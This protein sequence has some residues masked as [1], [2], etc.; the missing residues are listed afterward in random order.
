MATSTLFTAG[1]I[2]YIRATQKRSFLSWTIEQAMWVQRKRTDS[3]E[4]KTQDELNEWLKQKECKNDEIL[5]IPKS[6]I[7]K[8]QETWLDGMQTFVWNYKDDED[9][10]VVLYLHG[11]AYMNQPVKY[12]YKAVEYLVNKLDAK[13][14]FPVYPKTP[15]YTFKDT[16]VRLDKLYRDLVKETDSNQIS[17]VGDSAGGGLALGFAMYLRDKGLPQPKDIILSS[18]WL[19]VECGND[20][21]KDY[22]NK[23]P[24]LDLWAAPKIGLLWAGTKEDM[25]NPYVSPL[26]GSFENLGKIAIFVGTNEILLPDNQKLHEILQ[27][28]GIEHYY[29]VG[30]LM[31][32]DYVIYPIPEG[33]KALEKIVNIISQD[34]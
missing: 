3:S 5:P 1:F 32:H 22:E 30:H 10:K 14:V 19:D 21:I 8:V 28:Q 18:P 12:H 11:G 27:E 31:N 16:Y 9:Q 7:C 25:R 6:T 15:K 29:E 2:A 4:N 24:M 26:F 13:V 17:F 34:N 20:E 33:R 23:D